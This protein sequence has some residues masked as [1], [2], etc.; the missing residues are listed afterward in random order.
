MDQLNCK[1]FKRLEKIVASGFNVFYIWESIY[2]SN[3]KEGK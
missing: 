3:N 2:D 1:T